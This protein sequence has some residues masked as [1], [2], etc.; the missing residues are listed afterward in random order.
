MTTTP[1]RPHDELMLVAARLS[2]ATPN[3]WDEFLKAFEAYS[4]DRSRDCVAAPYDKI[5]LAQGRAQQCAELAKLFREA[6]ATANA[7]LQN[8]PQPM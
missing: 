5:Y 3:T 4:S 1:N 8:A 2:R 7:R 6:I